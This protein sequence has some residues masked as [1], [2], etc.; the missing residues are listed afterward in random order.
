MHH[1][2]GGPAPTMGTCVS[3][4]GFNPG[5]SLYFTIPNENNKWVTAGLQFGNS[6]VAVWLQSGVLRSERGVRGLKYHTLPVACA[7]D[8]ARNPTTEAGAKQDSFRL[9]RCRSRLPRGETMPQARK[10]G[11][12][13]GCEFQGACRVGLLTSEL[14][15][16]PAPKV[17]RP[18]ICARGPAQ[19]VGLS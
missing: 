12:A 4:A 7:H 13:A 19:G 10:S 11:D 2:P 14:R 9:G 17:R 16:L 5:D 18:V 15:P 6:P 3:T 8:K 1:E